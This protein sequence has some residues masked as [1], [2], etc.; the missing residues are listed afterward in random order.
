MK[1]NW[2]DGLR[3][4]CLD[5]APAKTSS[6]GWD[7]LKSRTSPTIWSSERIASRVEGLGSEGLL[8]GGNPT[9]TRGS[10][11]KK[12]M[13]HRRLD[14]WRHSAAIATCRTRSAARSIA[15]TTRICDDLDALLRAVGLKVAA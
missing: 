1:R 9:S 13:R 10:C 11:S 2:D 4:L 15:C 8:I 3:A 12:S 14:C 6:D 7:A 5:Q